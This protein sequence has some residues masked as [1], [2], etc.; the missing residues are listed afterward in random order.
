V[1]IHHNRLSANSRRGRWSSHWDHQSR[2]GSRPEQADLARHAAAAATAG[3]GRPRHIPVEAIFLVI[4]VEFVPFRRLAKMTRRNGSAAL[5]PAEPDIHQRIVLHFRVRRHRDGAC[6]VVG[7]KS[8]QWT[9]HGG[10]RKEREIR[11]Q[12]RG[13]LRSSPAQASATY[14]SAPDQSR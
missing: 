13:G 4:V 7:W 8:C 10:R 14:T 5:P 11:V 2:A 9:W 6:R 1:K 12:I 3:A